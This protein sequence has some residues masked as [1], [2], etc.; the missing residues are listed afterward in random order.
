MHTEQYDNKQVNLNSTRSVFKNIQI[1]PLF[2]C[3]KKQIRNLKKCA[4]YYLLIMYINLEL[5]NKTSRYIQS[6]PVQY[7]HV[8]N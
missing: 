6:P 7:F 8:I 5:E 2:T 4:N 3:N 1:K